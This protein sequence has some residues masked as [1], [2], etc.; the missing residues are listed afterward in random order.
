MV[1]YC[2]L[3]S[4]FFSQSFHYKPGKTQKQRPVGLYTS[5]VYR[6]SSRTTSLVYRVSSRPAWS[7]EW[8]PGQ[9]GLYSETL[10]QTNKQTNKQ[11]KQNKSKRTG[12]YRFC[13][14]AWMTTG[15]ICNSGCIPE[16]CICHQPGYKASDSLH[17]SRACSQS[18][19]DKLQGQPLSQNLEVLAALILSYHSS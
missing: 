9:P 15:M 7:T 18:A 6:V 2:F 12:R 3:L 16:P 1:S 14:M 4:V 5:L 11:P 10:S 8:V 13:C 17:I 19:T